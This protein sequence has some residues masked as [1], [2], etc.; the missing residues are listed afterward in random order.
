MT[1]ALLLLCATRA[2]LEVPDEIGVRL[3]LDGQLARRLLILRGRHAIDTD[4]DVSQVVLHDQ[5]PELWVYDPFD[6]TTAMQAAM[7]TGAWTRWG[8]HLGEPPTPD[9]DLRAERFELVI[10]RIG[11]WWQ[12]ERVRGAVRRETCILTWDVIEAAATA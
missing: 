11:V 6:E 1:P 12:F 10:A 7:E 2:D 5:T 8:S 4:A 3:R 9:S